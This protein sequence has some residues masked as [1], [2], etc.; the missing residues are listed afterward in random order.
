M[1]ALAYRRRHV[2]H[3]HL[4]AAQIIAAGDDVRHLKPSSGHQCDEARREVA[5]HGRRTRAARSARRVVPP[6]RPS[7]RSS[8]R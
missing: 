5:E 3:M 8:L 7:S 6:K 2:T 1:A 4:R